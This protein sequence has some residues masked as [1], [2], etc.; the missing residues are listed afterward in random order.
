MTRPSPAAAAVTGLDGLPV[1]HSL[2]DVV[3]LQRA[4]GP[5]YLRYSLGPCAD[6]S[7]ESRDEQ[8]GALLPGLSA[9]PAHPEPWWDRPAEEWVA[10]Q[11]C[12]Y[13]EAAARGDDRHGWILTGTESGRGA[14]CEPLL[15]ETTGLAVLHPACLA[16]ARALCARSFASDRV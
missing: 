14:D 6:A 8:S 3:R 7:E 10:R 16:E 13:A 9:R 2:G 5:V 12:Q 11:L 4:V 1:L 15:A